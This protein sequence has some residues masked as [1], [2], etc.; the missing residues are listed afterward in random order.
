MMEGNTCWGCYACWSTTLEYMTCWEM[1]H[2][3]I[4]CETYWSMALELHLENDTTIL[5]YHIFWSITQARDQPCFTPRK[6]TQNSH[7]IQTTARQILRTNTDLNKKT[8]LQYKT[9]ESTHI[10][11]KAGRIPQLIPR[12]TQHAS[13]YITRTYATRFSR[14]PRI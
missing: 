14:E 13:P 5:A 11:R 2:H 10:K 4:A 9:E 3:D 7:K 12:K 1:T 8:G 6:H